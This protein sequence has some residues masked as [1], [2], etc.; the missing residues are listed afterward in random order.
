MKRKWTVGVVALS[1]VL[2]IVPVAVADD[3][4]DGGADWN[5]F[6]SLRVRP[7]YN[8]N[9]TDVFGGQDD[10]IAY[11]NYRMNVGF[12]AE[13]DRNVAVHV[14]GQWIGLFG[15]DQTASRGFQGFDTNLSDFALYEAYADVRDVFDTPFSIRVGRQEIVLG[16]EWL[17]GDDHFYGGVTHDAIRGD[18]DTEL[19]DLTIFWSK[20]A[21]LDFPEFITSSVGATDIG[22]DRDV[23]TV[24][25]DW[26]LPGPQG[27]EAGIVYDLDRRPSGVAG[28]FASDKRWTYA[29]Q[30]SWGGETGLFVD[31]NAA[32]QWGKTVDPT[33]TLEVDLEDAK[34]FEGTVGWNFE[35]GGG[36]YKVYAMLA[37]YTGDDPSSS[38]VETFSPLFQDN[39]G[40]YGFADFWTGRWGFR[41]FLGASPGIGFLQL[42]FK[43]QLSNGI[44]IQVLAQRMRR[45]IAFSPTQ[46]NRNLGQEYAFVFSYDYGDNVDLELGFAQIFPGSAFRFEP[47]FLGNSTTRRFY[48]NTAVSF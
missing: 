39:H 47:P 29:A 46:S 37:D 32:I 31:A 36:T 17:F 2:G 6:G 34:G 9:L 26:E 40:R 11:V 45:D 13:L 15:E 33:G 3:H 18:W 7:E 41:P 1:L 25:S 43:S 27:I 5:W 14:D 30:Y 10:K 20:V 28:F 16:D 21:E 42:G 8:E 38:D 48:L 22:G 4:E 35:R 12:H 44:G 19:V 23:Y 24:W